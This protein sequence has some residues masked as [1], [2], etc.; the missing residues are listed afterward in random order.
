MRVSLVPKSLVTSRAHTTGR[1]LASMDLSTHDGI[2]ALPP[3]LVALITGHVDVATKP[4]LRCVNSTWNALLQRRDVCRVPKYGMRC[5]ITMC[6]CPN[7]CAIKF[8]RHLITRRRWSVFAWLLQMRFDP[9][10]IS[11]A[12]KAAAS[13]GDLQ[14][15]R[16]LRN[17]YGAEQDPL[18]M[19]VQAA[20]YGHRA[21]LEWLCVNCALDTPEKQ[22]ASAR[23]AKY[24]HFELL[25]QVRENGWPLS[26]YTYLGAFKNSNPDMI[27][28]LN[29]QKCSKSLLVCET[30]A[31]RGNL[32][33]LQTAHRMKFV[34]DFDTC[35]KAARHGHLHILQ[36]ARCNRYAWTSRVC[37]DAAKGGH[38][39][40]LQW[41]RANGCPWDGD[42]CDAAAKRGHAHVVKWALAN[43]CPRHRG[44]IVRAARGGNLDI[45]RLLSA[46]GCAWYGSAYAQA[47]RNGHL[48]VM[49]WAHAH[50]HIW[51][52]PLAVISG[53]ESFGRACMNAAEKG[54]LDIIEWLWS[55]KQFNGADI[56]A[57]AARGGHIHIIEWLRTQGCKWDAR[58]IKEAI[59]GSHWNVVEWARAHGCPEP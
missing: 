33:M 52:D 37:R 36:W 50:G 34:G 9:E 7:E 31:G 56:C 35:R 57:K 40:V 19:I 24:G 1:M 22:S 29:Q 20:K 21:T 16:N 43:G 48:H 30:M 11:C 4:A 5:G 25:K 17:H 59:G 54:H 44:I 41:L 23:M 12:R 51:D 8:A 42:A 3:E 14:L 26:T 49:Q 47:S 32:M 53:T 2:A 38:L 27:H 6:M 39:D 15:L 58:V 13:D 28:W 55:I 46:H 18:A 10:M 45:I